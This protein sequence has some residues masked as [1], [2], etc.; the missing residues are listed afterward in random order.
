MIEKDLFF[1]QKLPVNGNSKTGN[2][3]STIDIIHNISNLFYSFTKNIII[4]SV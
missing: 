4:L 2:A 3:C 1:L